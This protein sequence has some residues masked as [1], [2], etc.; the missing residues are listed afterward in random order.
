MSKKS[1]HNVPDG[2]LYI[3]G[4][5][6]EIRH[7]SSLT[8]E[9]MTPVLYLDLDGTVRMGYDELGKFV[10]GPEDV[11]V[12]LGV[13]EL[14]RRYKDLGWRIIG[15]SNQGG[16][17]KGLMSMEDCKAAMIET[18]RQTG[19]MFDKIAWC[20]HHPDA[21]EPE[22]AV[23]WCRKPRIGLIIESA[24]D[25]EKNTGENYPPH[26]GLFVGDMDSDKQTAENAG[27]AFMWA[28]DW[29]TGKHLDEILPED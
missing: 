4:D 10:N 7:I 11:H 16:I 23:C 26:L 8:G 18:Q 1:E 15:I 3:V 17:A 12:F 5:E 14:L 29:R 24:Y 25:L 9:K 21:A 20:I 13:P 19:G 6:N 2:R 27:L 28:K 22:M